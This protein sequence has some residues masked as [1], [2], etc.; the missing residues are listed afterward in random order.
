MKVALVVPKA[1]MPK[2]KYTKK[3]QRQYSDRGQVFPN[4]SLCYL[5]PILEREGH[6]VGIID[7]NVLCLGIKETIEWLREFQPEV[8]GFN[9]LTEGFKDMVPWMQAIKES[10]KLP[11]IVGGFHLKLYPRE[12]MTYNCIDY[13]AVGQAWHTFPE[14]LSAIENGERDMSGIKGLCYRENGE[15]VMTEPREDTTTLDEVPF[16]ARHLIPNERYSTILTKQW[17]ITVMLTGQGCPFHCLYCD[18]TGWYQPRDP[19]KVVDEVE[20]CIKRYDI[21]EFFFQDETFTVNRKRVYAICNELLRRGI[22]TGFAIRTR[23]D[24]VTREMLFLLKAAGCVRVNFGIETGDEEI[25][26]NIRRDVTLAQIRN[27]V[28]WAKEAKLVTLGFYLL[29]SPGETEETI[30]RTID[31][32]VELDTDYVSISKLV[33]VPNSELYE[34]IVK[35][36]G[37]DFWREYTLGDWD[38]INEIA[39]YK[40]QVSPEDL[41]HWLKKAYQAFYIRPRFILRTLSGVRSLRELYGL[42]TSAWSII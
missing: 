4:M 40:C 18:M 32:A 16:P 17:P 41:D 30:R 38:V 8:I 20:E 24:C 35:E 19:L 13:A 3:V 27:A 31:L 29:G 14:L 26:K 10:M 12:T 21:K 11:I 9:I 36:T 5:A 15:I 39:Y 7:S 34:L 28:G 42:L 37:R 22:K 1:E 25:S 6:E 33:P 23:A 2:L